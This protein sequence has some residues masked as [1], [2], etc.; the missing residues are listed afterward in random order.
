MA[1][2]VVTVQRMDVRAA[3]VLVNEPN[4]VFPP[5]VHKPVTCVFLSAGVAGM[6]SFTVDFVI[7]GQVQ[8]ST[9]RLHIDRM[10]STYPN[11]T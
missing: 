6:G 8:I 7:E 2:S 5:S 9:Y 3:S 4:N 10:H 1:L 11:M